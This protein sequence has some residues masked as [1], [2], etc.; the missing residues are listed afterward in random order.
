[1]TEQYRSC[2]WMRGLGRPTD[3]CVSV[4]LK[5]MSVLDQRIRNRTHPDATQAPLASTV[6][7]QIGPRTCHL[8]SA[9]R[10]AFL[11]WCPRLGL[12]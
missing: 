6:E 9:S 5:T 4:M 3:E 8:G 12:T 10:V 1:M 11:A 7:E 2:H